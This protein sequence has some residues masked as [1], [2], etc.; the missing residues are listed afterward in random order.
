MLRKALLRLT[1]QI[2]NDSRR[3]LQ[4]VETLPTRRRRGVSGLGERLEAMADQVRRVVR[5]TKSLSIRWTDP[6]SGQTGQCIRAA[7]GNHSQRKSG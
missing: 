2:L 1:R 5:Q 4:E 3:V 6:V 7:H